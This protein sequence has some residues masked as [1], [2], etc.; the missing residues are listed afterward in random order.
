MNSEDSDER[1]S[2]D[3]LVL[4]NKGY[5]IRVAARMAGVSVDTLRMWERRYDFPSPTRNPT[6]NRVYAATD[7]ERLILVARVIKLGYRAG[8]AMRLSGPEL[9]QVLAAQPTTIGENGQVSTSDVERLIS[10]IRACEVDVFRRELQRITGIVGTKR[11]IVELAAPL[12]EAV[13]EAWSTGKLGVHHEHLMT[14]ILSA[15]LRL[16]LHFQQGSMGP[17]LLL[18][19]LPR[20][21]HALGLDMAALMACMAGASV[22][23]VGPNTPTSDLAEAASALRVQAVGLSI[24]LATARAAAT[25]HI[26]WLAK[27]LPST[28]EFWLGGKGATLLEDLP[29]RVRVLH[30]WQDLD[31]AVEGLSRGV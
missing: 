17:R 22:E 19:T 8:E 31:A 2:N 29:T 11:F 13:G 12:V 3:R 16:Q 10:L 28:F 21:Q 5:T 1:Q 18:A 4:S 30:N 23:I 25:S 24:S 9:T 15:H 6:G 14:D 20:E 27:H 7:V 26:E